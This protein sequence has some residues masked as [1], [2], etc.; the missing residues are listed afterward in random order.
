[1]SQQHV[2]GQLASIEFLVKDNR[3]GLDNLTEKLDQ[4]LLEDKKEKG[5]QS[6]RLTRLET[7]VDAL[8]GR[9]TGNPSQDRQDT[10]KYQ[11]G[12]KR[13]GRENKQN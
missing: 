4:H 1:M 8:E 11:G 9:A 5:K 10:V 12:L 3:G 7:K 2:N 13:I 6:E